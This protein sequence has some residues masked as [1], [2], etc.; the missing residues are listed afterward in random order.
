V[1]ENIDYW[2][3][4]VVAAWLAWNLWT[5]ERRARIDAGVRRAAAVISLLLAATGVVMI[6]W[7]TVIPESERGRGLL[8][9]LVGLALLAYQ[10]SGSAGR[11]N[12]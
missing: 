1:I 8:L 5:R 2:L 9:V 12:D 10:R 6:V 4:V 11:G 7:P 3:L